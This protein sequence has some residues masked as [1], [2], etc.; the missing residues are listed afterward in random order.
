MDKEELKKLSPEAR[1]KKLQEIIEAKNKELEKASKDIEDAKKLAEKAKKDQADLAWIEKIKIP[2]IREVDVSELFHDE[3]HLEERLQGVELPQQAAEE[4][5]KALYK[6]NAEMP[7]GQMYSSIKNL[8]QQVIEQGTVT[9]D[10]AGQLQ[11]MQYA[12]EKKQE[13]IQAGSYNANQDILDQ[14][15]SIKS[16]A[17][18]ILSM[19][20][21][22]VKRADGV[23]LWK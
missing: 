22:G 16:I 10:V 19:Y 5:F 8:Y 14:A 4:E 13:D 7:T 6:V 3:E 11:M 17:D 21:G 12:I 9:A 23:H 2:E 20:T 15:N 18:K 1:I